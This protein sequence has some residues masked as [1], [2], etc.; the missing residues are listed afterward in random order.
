M[1]VLRGIKNGIY[2]GIILPLV[3]AIGVRIISF[4]KWKHWKAVLETSVAISTVATLFVVYWTLKEMQIQR[5]RTY[6]PFIIIEDTQVHI[7]WNEIEAGDHALVDK[8][9][10]VKEGETVNPVLVSVNVQN[11]GVGVATQIHTII[12]AK[13]LLYD[14]VDALNQNI[15]HDSVQYKIHEDEGVLYFSNGGK[16]LGSGPITQTNRLYL[17]PNGEDSLIIGISPLF[18]MIVREFFIQDLGNMLEDYPL[19]L[20]ISY[21]DVQGIS[22]SSELTLLCEP[23]FLTY[24]GDGSGYATYKIGLI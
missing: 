1:K 10:L 24:R 19:T 22:Y 14:M 18:T 6:S 5:D 9:P 2:R 11:I 3:N 12:D 13:K 23:V 4:F 8:N 15:E 16:T 17:L 21:Q 7:D 20:S